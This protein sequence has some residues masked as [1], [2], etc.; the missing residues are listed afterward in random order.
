MRLVVQRVKEATCIIDNEVKSSITQGYMVLLGVSNDDNK[1]IADKMIRKLL[2]LRIFEDENG[3]TNLSIDKIDGEIM[4]ISNSSLS[5][6]INY[7]LS[8]PRLFLKVPFSYNEK[9][10]KIEKVLLSVLEELK[11][12][13]AVINAEL[14][15]VQS[16]DSSNIKYF[17]YHHETD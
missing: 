11:K 7:N 6:V 9:I 4:I 3:K 8:A 5:K 2:K 12:D 13:K 16:F 15:G 10:E 17:L 1:E 14:L